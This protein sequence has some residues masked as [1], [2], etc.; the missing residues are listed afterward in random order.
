MCLPQGNACSCTPA[1]VGFTRS[2]L[3][4]AGTAVC[5]GQQVCRADAG[6]DDCDSSLTALELCDGLDND[7]D[8]KIDQPFINTQDSGTYDTDQ[9][10]GNCTTNCIAQW[11]PT[12]QHA[13]GGCRLAP[14]PTCEIVACTSSTIPG[15]KLCQSNADCGGG[16][17]DPTFHQCAC[18]GTTCAAGEICSAGFCTRACMTGST[19]SG[20][21][22]ATSQCGDAGVCVVPYTFVDADKD[23]TNG[24]ECPAASGLADAPDVFPT[25]PAAGVAYVDRDC[26]GID[27]VAAT[28]L[29][30]WAQTPNSQGT[31]AKPYRTLREAVQAFDPTRNTA[32]LV[33]QGSYTEQV[34]LKNGV[35]IFGGYSSDFTK[36]DVVTFPTLIEAPEPD[37]SSTV[38]RGS[39]NAEN[40]TST[41]VLAGFTIRGY[42]VTTRA[43]AGQPGLQHVRRFREEFAGPHA[44]EQ[45]HLRR[46]RGRRDSRGGRRGGRLGRVRLARSRLSRVRD[47]RLHRR[48]AARRRGRHEP[49]VPWRG[50]HS[51]RALD[52]HVRPAGLPGPAR[53]ERAG[54]SER[55]LHALR[56]FAGRAVQVRLHAAEWSTERRPRDERR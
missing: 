21:Y 40:L 8:G 10:C 34:V 26:D 56:P 4:T 39:V 52:P 50:R 42:D 14:A 25:Y 12:I 43:L 16:V 13:I 48:A 47:A 7:C 22:G 28:S 44:R 2:C 18:N 1:R 27:G 6:F 32:I 15:G 20:A 38:R 19:C 9:H 3:R 24:C 41:T 37:F 17:C 51:G 30:V 46:P 33:A 53:A 36:R 49:V 55:H 45:P 31:R 35:Q 5:I 54:R 29:F 11:S 23:S